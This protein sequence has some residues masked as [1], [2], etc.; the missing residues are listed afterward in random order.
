MAYTV[1]IQRGYKMV[2]PEKRRRREKAQRKKAILKAARRLF[3]EHGFR[4]VTVESIAK[5]AELSKGAVY[6]YFKSK[7]EIYGQILQSDIESF[8]REMLQ[9]FQPG[10]QASKI[11]FDFADAYIDI[12]LNEREQ[13]RTLMNFMLNAENLKLS[14][15]VRKEIIRETNSTISLLEKILQLGVDSGEFMNIK[16]HK[17]YSLRNILWG[18]LNGIISLHLFVGDELTRE[19]RIRSGVREGVEAVI[20]GLKKNDC[21]EK[22]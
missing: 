13:F 3:T 14:R 8:H 21:L 12:F 2:G 6:L 10:R 19:E 7:E 18:L 4:P 15:D 9:T 17:I 1:E 5:K 11:L 20:A 16:P 22:S